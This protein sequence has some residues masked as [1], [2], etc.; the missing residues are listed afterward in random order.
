MSFTTRIKNEIS[1]VYENTSASFSELSAILRNS[2][3][4]ER[5]EL[6]IITENGSVCKHI[7]T[8]RR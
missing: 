6:S 3:N 2:Y 7:Y 4:V 1:S 8:K 5:K